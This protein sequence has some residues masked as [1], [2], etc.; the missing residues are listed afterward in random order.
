MEHNSL[1]AGQSADNNVV[2]ASHHTTS[3]PLWRLYSCLSYRPQTYISKHHEKSA[4]ILFLRGLL[5]ARVIFPTS[6]TPIAM[7][8][9]KT[10]ATGVSTFC[11]SLS[12]APNCSSHYSILSLSLIYRASSRPRRCLLFQTTPPSHLIPH[13]HIHCHYYNFSKK[14]SDEIGATFTGTP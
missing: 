7:T 11:S 4:H 13:C 9:T 3:I 8:T 10:G 2:G 5:R 14:N 12:T 6:G 1:S